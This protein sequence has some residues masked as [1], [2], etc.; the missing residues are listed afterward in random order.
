MG[1][2]T[3]FYEVDSKGKRV[4]QLTNDVFDGVGNLNRSGWDFWLDGDLELNKQQVLDFLPK[5]RKSII[6]NYDGDESLF[7]ESRLQLIMNN[8]SNLDD[9]IKIRVEFF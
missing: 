3:Y 9:N 5:W 7:S 8:V 1:C 2:N 6:A 4:R